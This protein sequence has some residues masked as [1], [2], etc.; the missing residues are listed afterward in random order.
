[1]EPRIRSPPQNSKN[2]KGEHPKMLPTIS[3]ADVVELA[4]TTVFQTDALTGM[5]VRIPPSAP[6]TLTQNRPFMGEQK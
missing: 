3:C 6:S 2:S 1:M 5:W 4:D